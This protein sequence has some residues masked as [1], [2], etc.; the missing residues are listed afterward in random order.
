MYDNDGNPIEGDVSAQVKLWD[1]GTR[2]N[3]VPGASV[4][5]PGTADNKN[6]MEVSGMDAQGNTYLAAS[7]LV[8]VNG[9]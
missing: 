8:K 7:Q 4:M 6:I 9:L 1:N 3:Q 5:H 2:V